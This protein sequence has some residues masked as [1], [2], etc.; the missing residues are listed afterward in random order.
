MSAPDSPQ[1]NLVMKVQSFWSEETACVTVVGST[2]QSS[3]RSLRRD[4]RLSTI[5]RPQRFGDVGVK[6]VATSTMSLPV[7]I[8][9]SAPLALDRQ[10]V[11]AGSWIDKVARVVHGEVRVTEPPDFRM[12]S[13]MI[14]EL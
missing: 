13:E 14:L 11:S 6:A 2:W 12:Q 3:S 1:S 10:G 7:G 9:E 4:Q 5:V 8:L